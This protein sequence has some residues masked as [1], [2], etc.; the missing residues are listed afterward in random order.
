MVVTLTTPRLT[1]R[2]PG[3]G[4]VDAIVEGLNDFEV[5]RFLTKVP[6]PYR[7]EDAH[8]WLGTLTPARPGDARFAIELGGRLIGVVG[9]EPQ[10]GF[11]LDRRHHGRGL[12]TEAAAAL[13]DW[14]FASTPEDR[15]ASAAHAGNEAS[16]NVQRKLGFRE[17]GVRTMSTARSLGREVEHIETSLTRADFYAARQVLVRQALGRQ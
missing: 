2:Q 11:W 17:T 8:W 5:T 16:L 9:L 6:F 14:H 1:L 10:L 4:D 7:A 12:M 3:P 15:V 13:L